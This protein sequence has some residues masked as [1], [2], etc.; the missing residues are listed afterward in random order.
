MFIKNVLSLRRSALTRHRLNKGET[1]YKIPALLKSSDALSS[2]NKSPPSGTGHFA[3]LR[4]NRF[5]IDWVIEVEVDVDFSKRNSN[6]FRKSFGPAL[7]L[8]DRWQ[9]MIRSNFHL[10]TL[11]TQEATFSGSRFRSNFLNIGATKSPLW[12]FLKLGLSSSTQS[13][14]S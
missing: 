10:H 7:I 4:W 12:S 5:K 9:G 3:S 14:Y 13:H 1:L 11:S 6:A 2:K 8:F